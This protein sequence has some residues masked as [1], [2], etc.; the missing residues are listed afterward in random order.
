MFLPTLCSLSGY[1][2]TITTYGYNVPFG[3]AFRQSMDIDILKATVLH[4]A[5][6]KIAFKPIY[7]S[8]FHREH[9]TLNRFYYHQMLCVWCPLHLSYVWTRQTLLIVVLSPYGDGHIYS[10]PHSL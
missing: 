5:Y 8:S 10:L 7:D 9:L 6:C 1:L 4:L 3:Y 2:Y